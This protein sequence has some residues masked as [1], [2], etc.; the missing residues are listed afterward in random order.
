MP[1]ETI[2]TGTDAASA[3]FIEVE[4]VY[5]KA[6]EQALVCLKLIVG[7]TVEA[8]IVASGLLDRFP[9]ID[10]DV[11]KVGIFGCICNL[12]RSLKRNDRVEIYHPLLHDPKDSR[13]QRAAKR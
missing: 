8:A 1:D 7:A 2:L 6:E 10:L 12:D 11:N 4:V 9:E 5:A 13:K 3:R